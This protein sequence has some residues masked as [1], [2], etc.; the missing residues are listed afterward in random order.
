MGE[1]APMHTQG[2]PL[3][4]IPQMSIDTRAARANS[5]AT[6]DVPERLS[7]ETTN[8]APRSPRNFQ[9]PFSRAQTSLDVDDYFV[10]PSLHHIRYDN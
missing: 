1:E 4:V 8:D 3:N 6:T 5:E 9:N 2:K 10:R 7:H